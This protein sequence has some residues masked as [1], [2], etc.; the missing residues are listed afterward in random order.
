VADQIRLSESESET[1]R[2][3]IATGQSTLRQLVEAEVQNYRARDR[4]IATQ[5]ERLLLLLAIA[6]RTGALVDLI[7]LKEPQQQ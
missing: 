7:G 3:Q 5:A 2:S 6:A 4:Q 1:S